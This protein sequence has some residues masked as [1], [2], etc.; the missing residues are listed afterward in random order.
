MFN[1]Y[2]KQLCLHAYLIIQHEAEAEDIVQETFIYLWKNN[3]FNDISGSLNAYLTISVKNACFNRIKKAKQQQDVT[4]L[5]AENEYDISDYLL[6]ENANELEN[7]Y[8][9]MQTAIEEL[10]AQCKRLFK[11]VYIE[12]KKYSEAAAIAEV[13]VNTVKTQLKVAFVKL[14]EILIKKEKKE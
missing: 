1:K 9:E 6:K 7:K 3:K 5:Y 11:L 13:S 12:K 2:Y 14:R 4:S 10:P 8:L